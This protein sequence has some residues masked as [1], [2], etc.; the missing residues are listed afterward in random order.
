MSVHELGDGTGYAGIVNKIVLLENE[1]C[2][3][4]DDWML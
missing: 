3:G 1:K 2:S 4:K